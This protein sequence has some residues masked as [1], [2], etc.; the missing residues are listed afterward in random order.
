MLAAREVVQESLGFS[1]NQLVF[2]HKIRGPLAVL[3]DGL[4][5]EEPPKSLVEYV[6]SF[7]RRLVLAGE[8]ARE[9]LGDAQ[10]TMKGLFD[11]GSESREFTS[12]DQVLA[13]LPSTS[14]PLCAKF[15][16]LYSVIRKMSEQ[17]YFVS[18]PDRRK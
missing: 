1:P 12:G 2:G 14:S 17:N 6:H 5:R 9:K 4:I 8:C 3:K 11:W 15:V 13:L 10:A 7:R 16:G 18:T